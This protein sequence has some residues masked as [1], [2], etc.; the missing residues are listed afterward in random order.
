M[1]VPVTKG[2]FD[3]KEAPISYFSTLVF[4]SFLINFFMSFFDKKKAGTSH[5]HS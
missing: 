5:I 2:C 4:I 3:P 1:I